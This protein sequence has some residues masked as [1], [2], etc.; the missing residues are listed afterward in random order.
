MI[1]KPEERG[2]VAKVAKDLNINHHTAL[3][4]RNSYKETEKILYKKSKENSGPKSSF[5]TKHNEYLQDLLDNDPQLFSDGIMKSLTEQLKALLSPKSQLHGYIKPTFH[6]YIKI[7][8]TCIVQI[9]FNSLC[10]SDCLSFS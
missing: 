9:S 1:E 5:T 6:T 7:Y 10:C 3:R 4:L 8:Y 2:L